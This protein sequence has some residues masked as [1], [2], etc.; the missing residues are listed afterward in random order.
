MCYL[1]E[2]LKLLTLAIIHSHLHNLFVNEEV[3]NGKE[4]FIV[5]TTELFDVSNSS[6]LWVNTS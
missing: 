4:M 3:F 2:Q 6:Y 1:C 5:P